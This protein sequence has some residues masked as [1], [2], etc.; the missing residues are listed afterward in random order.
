MLVTSDTIHNLVL[1]YFP[2]V[3]IIQKDSSPGREHPCRMESHL[4]KGGNHREG[5]GRQE[6][7]KDYRKV[8]E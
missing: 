7:S 1:V 5:S 4:C 6:E 3:F 2:L 8:Y